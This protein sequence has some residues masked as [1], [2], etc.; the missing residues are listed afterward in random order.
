MMAPARSYSVEID[1]LMALGRARDLGPGWPEVARLLETLRAEPTPQ[2]MTGAGQAILSIATL[3][4]SQPLGGKNR[5][6]Q[7]LSKRSRPLNEKV[8]AAMIAA[9]FAATGSLV[10]GGALPHAAGR[11]ASTLPG[12][13]QVQRHYPSSEGTSSGPTPLTEWKGEVGNRPS[14]RPSSPQRPTGT[15]ARTWG[16]HGVTQGGRKQPG[17]SGRSGTGNGGNQPPAQQ[18][19]QDTGSGK[20]QGGDQGKGKDYGKGNDSGAGRSADHRSVK[21]S[22][23]VKGGPKAQRAGSGSNKRGSRHER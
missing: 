1:E 10:I 12:G 19:G 4:R 20:T 15:K 22:T 8:A 18:G 3:I 17:G 6:P 14:V 2:E 23:T 13:F 9:A 7:A 11:S 5:V 16:S 21:T